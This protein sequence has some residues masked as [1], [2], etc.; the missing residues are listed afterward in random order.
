MSQ[1]PNGS[2]NAATTNT[3]TPA[4]PAPAVPRL[5]RDRKFERLTPWQEKLVEEHLELVDKIVRGMLRRLPSHID[6]SDLVQQ[7]RMGLMEAARRYD[8]TSA[9][10]FKTFATYR[11]RGE[12]IDG[13]RAF[14][15]NRP[16]ESGSWN[17]SVEAIGEGGGSDDGIGS[18]ISSVQALG[19]AFNLATST[20]ENPL[21]E[22]LEKQA[23]WTAVSRL[24]ERERHVCE[25]LY[26]MDMTMQDIADVMHTSK[27][28]VS[29]LHKRALE[30]L[31]TDRQLSDG[32]EIVA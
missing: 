17:E 14:S 30:R 29:R 23:L 18:F 15:Q 6:K 8:P 22:S 24:P 13:M 4:T 16:A 2:S 7:G 5:K 1:M 21:E 10:S 9:A 28:S 11:I 26:K 3:E 20:T 12:I 31:R 27:A 25:L 19:M 32:E